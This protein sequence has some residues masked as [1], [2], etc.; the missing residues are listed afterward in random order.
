VHGGGAESTVTETWNDQADDTHLLE[1]WMQLYGTDVMNLTYSYVHN[2]HQAQDIVQDVFLKAFLKKD[3]FRGQSSVKTW[4][5]SIT[6]NRCKDYLRSW[7]VKHV[8][9]DEN[10]L[11][12]KSS[13]TDT[14]VEVIRVLENDEVWRAVT[15]LP[16]KYRE[17]IVLFYQRDLNIQEVAD[18][19]N[20]SESNV[21]TRL[22]RGRGLLKQQLGEG[23]GGLDTHR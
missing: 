14:E 13:P 5:L 15:L 10:P 2:Y 22:H 20:V 3:S 4:L 16:I 8:I 21:R 23:G 19:L 1:S 18:V 6:A 12:Q 11:I 7:T 17:V 9:H